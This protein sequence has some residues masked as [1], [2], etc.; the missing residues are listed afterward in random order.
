MEVFFEHD[1]EAISFCEHLFQYNK[2]IELY[3]RTHEEWGNQLQLEIGHADGIT[4]TT[5]Q[6]MMDVFN[7]H[8]L[9]SLISGIIKTHY[10][11]SNTEE[12]DR[13]TDIAQWLYDGEDE[14]SRRV[15]KNR[16]PSQLLKSIIIGNLEN[17]DTIHFDSILKFQTKMFKDQLIH[18]VGLAIDEYKREEDHQAF[19]DS[20]REYI[21]TRKATF[22]TVHILQGNPF[23][24]FKPDGKQFTRMELRMLMH[25][26][27][28]Y[29]VGLDEEELNLA[30]LIAMAPDKI[31]IY[32]DYPSEPKT[33]TVINVFQEKAEF[34]PFSSF[35]FS[36]YLKNKS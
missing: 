17:T 36:N 31:T 27:P 19:V 24:F 35:P 15:R 29:M 16:D 14:D 13:I 4:S 2:R 32:G 22:S 20:L 8:R 12:I 30:P 10:Y 33:L 18:F 9:T 5:A 6:A 26:E 11:Y 28:L 34:K 25:K 7:G 21:V 3:W 23:T 1:K